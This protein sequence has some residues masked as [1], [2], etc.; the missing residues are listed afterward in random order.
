MTNQPRSYKGKIQS[1]QT[2]P[3]GANQNVQTVFENPVAD[4]KSIR[5]TAELVLG[6]KW[7]SKEVPVYTETIVANTWYGRRK[8][9]RNTYSTPGYNADEQWAHN[10]RVIS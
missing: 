9:R 7:D 3:I 1:A 6:R 10:I 5:T 4:N 2:V 8:K